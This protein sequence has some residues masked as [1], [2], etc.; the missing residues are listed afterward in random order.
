MNLL[1]IPGLDGGHLATYAIEGAM[2]R[3][4]P[5]AVAMRMVQAGFAVIALLGVFAITLDIVALS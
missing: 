3:D 4:L 1:P 2:R 5:K